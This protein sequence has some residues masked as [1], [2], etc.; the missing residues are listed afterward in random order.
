MVDNGATCC[1][2]DN[3]ETILAISFI[4]CACSNT[5]TPLVRAPTGPDPG[6]SHSY[7]T[8]GPHNC[9]YRSCND[10]EILL[11]RLMKVQD[12]F[13]LAEYRRHKINRTVARESPTSRIKPQVKGRKRRKRPSI[14]ALPKEDISLQSS[15]G[16]TQG[17]QKF[18]SHRSSRN[19]EHG[20]SP[21][22]LP[23]PPAPHQRGLGYQ[24]LW[25]V[26]L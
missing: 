5:L 22:F 26:E 2:H 4:Y 3:W 7:N 1:A 6:S 10:A 21:W 14:K 15:C 17:D 9:A 20:S 23:P 24:Q 13:S 19:Q 11:L 18:V 8:R 16:T 25:E 12:H